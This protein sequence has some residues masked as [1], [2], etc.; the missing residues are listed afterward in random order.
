MKRVFDLL[1]SSSLLVILSPL[2]LLTAVR[3]LW[4]PVQLDESGKAA[5]R[6][7]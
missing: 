7:S 1:V 3:V 2:I 5:R 6:Q 4:A